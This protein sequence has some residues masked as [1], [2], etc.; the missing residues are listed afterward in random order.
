MKKN[1]AWLSLVLLLAIPASPILGEIEGRIWPVAGP[2][3]IEAVDKFEN[4]WTYFSMSAPKN[5]NCNWRS[6]KFFLGKR[7][8]GN[9]PV[10]F[11]HLD[12]PQ[13]RETG[14]HYWPSSRVQLTPEQLLSNAY[15]DVLH[16]CGSGVWLT[17]TR[18]YN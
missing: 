3:N 2:A 6:T 1:F 9:V 16:V 12:P 8:N 18:F 4:G 14:R 13:L 10:A 15:A 5:R 7:G 17:R 11:E